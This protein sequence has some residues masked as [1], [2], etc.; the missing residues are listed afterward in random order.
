MVNGEKDLEV[1]R[2]GR[3]WGC[4]VRWN[5]AAEISVVMV[6]QKSKSVCKTLGRQYPSLACISVDLG[7]LDQASETAEDD[8]KST[9]RC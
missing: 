9:K 5:M 7:D 6:G 3:G 8:V 1:M 4:E 2:R